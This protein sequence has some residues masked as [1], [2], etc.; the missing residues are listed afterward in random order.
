MSFEQIWN[1]GIRVL[2]ILLAIYVVITNGEGL[3]PRVKR[4]FT[5]RSYADKG[6]W[7][8]D[9]TMEPNTLKA[10]LHAADLNYGSRIDIR[11]TKDGTAIL[12]DSESV[13]DI[14][15][16]KYNIRNLDFSELS[17]KLA[18]AGKKVDTLEELL[19]EMG[20]REKRAPILLNLHP[21]SSDSKDIVDF[22]DK[23]TKVFYPYRFFCAVESHNVDV[24]KYY[25]RNYS[26]IVRG[27]LMLPRDESYLS[28]KEYLSL[29]HMTTNI[30]TRPQFFD[31]TK[32]LYSRYYW[33]PITMG[34]FVILRGVTDEPSR[35]EAKKIYGVEAVVFSD[36]NPKAEF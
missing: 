28:D 29:N 35:I 33:A 3:F 15:G 4:R 30:K 18:P 23:V 8:D 32:E 21:D 31:T 9:D 13:D 16:E 19:T 14:N 11:L 5:H 17:E 1:S 34:S 20:K 7:F 36:G 2:M 22:C 12:F 25:A 6:L 27:M 10:V 26:N 24:I